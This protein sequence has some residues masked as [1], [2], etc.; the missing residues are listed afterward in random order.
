[1]VRLVP[2]GDTQQMS[3]NHEATGGHPVVGRH[4]GPAQSHSNKCNRMRG[5]PPIRQIRAS[6]P[7]R[8]FSQRD[9]PNQ[10]LPF[11]TVG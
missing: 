1:M 9:L 10:A 11:Q 3:L 6:S 2:E 5:W 7:G 8:P 4:L